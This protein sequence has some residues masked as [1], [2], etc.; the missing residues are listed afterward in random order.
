MT[1]ASLCGRG[2]AIELVRDRQ[3]RRRIKARGLAQDGGWWMEC[4]VSTDML[5][6]AGSVP[7]RKGL[8]LHRR[9]CA[10]RGR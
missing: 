3:K 9:S 8:P 10:R 7:K 6:C 4:K 1:Y 2:Q 5:G